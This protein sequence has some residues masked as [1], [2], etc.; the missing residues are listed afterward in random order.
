M[1]GLPVLLSGPAHT[2]SATIHATPA[3]IA[4]VAGISAVAAHART[5]IVL[6]SA[7]TADQTVVA[8]AAS[9]WHIGRNM[10]TAVGSVIRTIAPAIRPVPIPVRAVAIAIRPVPATTRL[11]AAVRS[12]SDRKSVV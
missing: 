2:A 12:I 1:L 3:A 9:V 7:V 6:H 10:P 8:I 11:I 5:R 4:F